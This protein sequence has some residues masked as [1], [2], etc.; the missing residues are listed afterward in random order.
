[1]PAPS[2]GTRPWGTLTTEEQ[3]D[4]LIG[5]GTFR[6]RCRRHNAKYKS[7][8]KAYYRARKAGRIPLE[9][10]CQREPGECKTAFEQNEDGTAAAEYQAIRYSQGEADRIKTLPQLLDLAQGGRRRRAGNG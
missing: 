1:M 9:G 5:P 4:I 3:A 6:D 8:E 10:N 2:T 7:A